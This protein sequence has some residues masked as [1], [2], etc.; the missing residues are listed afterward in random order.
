MRP[1]SLTLAIS[2]LFGAASAAKCSSGCATE[3]GKCWAH[4]C[5][6]LADATGQAAAD[7]CTEEMR[8]GTGPIAAHCT[9]SDCELTTEMSAK[10]AETCGEGGGGSSAP[11]GGGPSMCSVSVSGS[12]ATPTLCTGAADEVLVYTLFV[13]SVQR[14]FSLVNMPSASSAQPVVMMMQGYG[15]DSKLQ[16]DG[17]D[18][19]A[20]K[21]YGFTLLQVTGNLKDGGGGFSLQFGNDGVVNDAGPTPCSAADSRDIAF[22]STILDWVAQQSGK[23]D[24][25]KVFTRGFSQNSMFA[26]YTAV[27]FADKVAGIW[28]GGSGL[29]KTGFSPV[30]PWG[31]AQCALS[32]FQAAG[33]SVATCCKSSFCTACKYW[34]IYP[35]TCAKTKPERKLIDCIVA[36]T[37]DG[38]ACGTDYYAFEAMVREGNDARL[39][40]FA[41]VGDENDKANKQKGGHQDPQNSWAWASGCLGLTTPCSATCETSF[42][43]CA[44]STVSPDT[45]ATCEAQLKAGSL[46]GCTL[47]CSPTL[48]MLQTSESPVVSL[49]EGKFG[50]TTGLQ[51]SA[52]ATRPQCTN[53]FGPFATAPSACKPPSSWSPGE[54]SFPTSANP[55]CAGDRGDGGNSEGIGEKSSDGAAS[56][57]SLARVVVGVA[58]AVC[59][60]LLGM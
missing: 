18:A 13:D 32:K 44:G 55:L 27:C 50:A 37:N 28:Q 34:P 40:S 11:G 39:L 5:G 35:Q 20:A 60:V 26:A 15:G 21:Y 56:A 1:L 38:I 29:A 12:P 31:Q 25:G 33:N 10:A 46:D 42:K 7:K 54:D 47:G 17:A 4:Q 23:L 16:A 49:S 9:V 48:G 59:V 45:F 52:T 51:V 36:Y 41:P 19:E 22:L 30:V 57:A 43:A 53:A 6:S 58:G 24:K 2:A 3:Y 8:A 14:Y